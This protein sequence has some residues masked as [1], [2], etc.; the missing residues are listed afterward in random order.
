MNAEQLFEEIN[1][2]FENQ[3]P[4]Y[5]Q[6]KEFIKEKI[7]SKILLPGMKLPSESYFV[8]KFGISRIV[9]S[10]ALKEL[11]YEGL[12][13]RSRGKGTFVSEPKIT[14]GFVQRLIG[15]NQ[16]SA[17]KGMIAKTKVLNK[18]IIAADGELAKILKIKAGDKVIQITRLRYLV[19]GGDIPNHIS[20]TNLPLKKCPKLID[21]DLEE[22]SLYS[23]LKSEYQF[24]ITKGF[25]V[26]EAIPANEY[27]AKLLG[28]TRGTPLLKLRSVSYLE[29]ETPIEYYESVYRGDKVQFEVEVFQK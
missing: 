5:V 6:L 18:K 10:Q 14:Q 8:Q 22:Q 12:V 15:F 19:K 23:F 16:D 27:Q 3:I 25:R 26:I 24:V 2:N 9:I 4:L 7:D 13:F 11:A 29:D 1:L 28:I 17:E 20:I 21:V